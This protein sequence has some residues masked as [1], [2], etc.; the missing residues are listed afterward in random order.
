MMVYQAALLAPLIVWAGP[1]VHLLFGSEYGESADV[2]RVLA[3]YIFLDGLSPLISTTVNYLGQATKRIP[4]VVSA[5]VINVILDLVL[6]P[7]VGVVG[8]A[9]GATVAYAVYVPAHFRI[10]RRELRLNTRPLAGTLARAL[11]AAFC[12]ALVL[13]AIGTESLSPLD[14]FLGGTL[15]VLAF[16]AVLV[17]T[18]EITIG[19]LRRGSIVASSTMSRFVQSNLR[20][21]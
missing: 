5:L 3:F 17:V 16:M 8:A 10:C 18:R 9:I 19:D 14:Y 11:A 12:M 7:R 20:R 2:L 4:I 6:L 21:P 15:G 1:I 13:Y